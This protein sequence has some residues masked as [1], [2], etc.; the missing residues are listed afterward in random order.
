RPQ[1]KE[2]QY[3]V[4]REDQYAVLDTRVEYEWKTPRCTCC[5]VFGHVQDECPKNKVSDVVSKKNNVSTSG[6]KKKDA[7]P[8][9]EVSKSN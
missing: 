7:V 9:E 1:R 6:N 5:K 3:A 2:D 8:T 4:S